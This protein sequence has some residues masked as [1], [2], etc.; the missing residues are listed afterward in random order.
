M[1]LTICHIAYVMHLTSCVEY[2]VPHIEDAIHHT[3]YIIRHTSYI[4]YQHENTENFRW[5]GEPQTHSIWEFCDTSIF[6]LMIFFGVTDHYFY[7]FLMFSKSQMPQNVII[8]SLLWFS[9][10]FSFY[11]FWIFSQR[12]CS[13][14]KYVK[15]WSS[16]A[17][18][19][20]KQRYICIK[21]AN[22]EPAHLNL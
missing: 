11:N 2:R 14:G 1:A 15:Y 6:Q 7:H 4:S 16:G 12:Q 10:I 9:E 20:S 5:R 21:G 19:L 18:L 3:S 22:K 13:H 17:L 8:D